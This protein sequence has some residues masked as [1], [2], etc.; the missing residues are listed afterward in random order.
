MK[1]V[2]VCKILWWRRGAAAMEASVSE[3][4]VPGHKLANLNVNDKGR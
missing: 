3:T 2:T 4:A 1:M